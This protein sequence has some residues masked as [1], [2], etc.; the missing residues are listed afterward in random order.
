MYHSSLAWGW[1]FLE[2]PLARN[3]AAG[4]TG[5]KSPGSCYGELITMDRH[6]SE[7]IP[8]GATAMVISEVTATVMTSEMCPGRQ[9]K[10]GLT[11]TTMIH[12]HVPGTRSPEVRALASGSSVRTP[13]CDME[14]VERL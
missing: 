9:P 10:R 8:N 1:P 13:E 5:S 3:R 7:V 6:G 12:P 11:P 2:T 4:S 14:G